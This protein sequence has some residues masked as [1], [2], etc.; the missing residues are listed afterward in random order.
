MTIYIL[1]I[2][3]AL[4]KFIVWSWT[5]AT[6]CASGEMLW[7]KSPAAWVLTEK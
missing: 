6:N 1:D 3:K 2:F 5:S 7:K 4:K